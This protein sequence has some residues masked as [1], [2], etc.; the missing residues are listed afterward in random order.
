MSFG[1]TA[2]VFNDETVKQA[3]GLATT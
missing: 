1:P 3:Y 2:E